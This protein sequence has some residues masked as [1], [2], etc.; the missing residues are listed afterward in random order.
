M[1]LSKCETLDRNR[2]YI[3]VSI[4]NGILFITN[5]NHSRSALAGNSKF[6]D[7]NLRYLLLVII[8]F[9]LPLPPKLAAMCEGKRSFFPQSGFGFL[10]PAVSYS[11]GT[12]MKINLL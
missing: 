11:S 1:L 6:Y 5:L 3:V 2:N 4:L 8:S 10:Y 12:F 7:V 9:H